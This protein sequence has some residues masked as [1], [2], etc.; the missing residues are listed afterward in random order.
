MIIIIIPL[1][2]LDHE[3]ALFIIIFKIYLINKI[4]MN[5]L[6]YIVDSYNIFKQKL[7]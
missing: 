7:L 4:L 5:V 6:D 2:F 3:Y 1:K